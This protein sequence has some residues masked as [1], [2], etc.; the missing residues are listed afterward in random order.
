M[1][2]KLEKSRWVMFERTSR[3][4]GTKGGRYRVLVVKGWTRWNHEYRL[5]GFCGEG[6]GELRRNAFDNLVIVLV[7]VGGQE[8]RITK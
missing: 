7:V 5:S 2:R 3:R 4:D 1:M 8:K 6:G